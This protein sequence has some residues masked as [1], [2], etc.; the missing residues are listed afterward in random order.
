MR[1]AVCLAAVLFASLLAVGVRTAAACPPPPQAESAPGLRS[2]TS[3]GGGPSYLTDLTRGDP[4]YYT[5]DRKPRPTTTHSQIPHLP[6]YSGYM[7]TNDTYRFVNVLE[8]VFTMV[9]EG[10]HGLWRLQ[11]NG[12]I[13]EYRRRGAVGLPAGADV[14]DPGNFAAIEE[15]Y[16]HFLPGEG[17]DGYKDP[18]VP[19]D[20]RGRLNFVDLPITHPKY[21]GKYRNHAPID[22]PHWYCTMSEDGFRY[23]ENAMKFAF[24]QPGA[25]QIGPLGKR[26]G[27]DINELYTNVIRLEQFPDARVWVNVGDSHNVHWKAIDTSRTKAE[28]YLYERPFFNVPYLFL[29]VVFDNESNRDFRY[30]RPDGP[31]Y[32]HLR[33]RDE[34]L[35]TDVTPAPRFHLPG[36]GTG[37]VTGTPLYGV[38]HPNRPAEFGT[39]GGGACPEKG[40]DWAGYPDTT[41]GAGWPTQYEEVTPLCDGVLVDIKFYA[42]LDGTRWDGESAYLAN[43]G[44]GKQRVTYTVEEGF[45]GRFTDPYLTE[46]GMKNPHARSIG[47]K[48]VLRYRTVRK[49]VRPAPTSGPGGK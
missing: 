36:G 49:P 48:E 18:F 8:Q 35:K 44:A 4:F 6:V 15:D 26:A 45:Y 42:N 20:D 37:K 12:M 28:Y 40:G 22:L 19:V 2:F 3:A 5:S 21:R 43:A 38:H 24:A 41:G 46:R 30:V 10:K 29:A 39:K 14:L 11:E 34:T 23:A 9:G 16:S 17:V 13:R 25:N 1:R 31:Y 47:P 7:Q 32:Q 33:E 27:L